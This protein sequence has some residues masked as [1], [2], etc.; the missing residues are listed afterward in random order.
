MS[1]L[2]Y[3][4]PSLSADEC[5]V[6]LA[7]SP[8]SEH[9][10]TYHAVDDACNPKEMKFERMFRSVSL[11]TTR[12]HQVLR[13]DCSIAKTDFDKLDK[14]LCGTPIPRPRANGWNC[15]NWLRQA[16]ESLEKEGLLPNT[17]PPVSSSKP[18]PLIFDATEDATPVFEILSL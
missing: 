14:A 5:H 8:D 6:A 10:Y 12:P 18:F 3:A 4:A 11:K 2:M 16:L 17:E 1:I 15:Q 13:P 7:V 9:F